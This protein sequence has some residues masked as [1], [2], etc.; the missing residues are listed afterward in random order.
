MGWL[1][2]YCEP[3]IFSA[4]IAPVLDYWLS[5]GRD[6][7][8]EVTGIRPTERQSSLNQYP[9]HKP[10]ARADPAKSFLS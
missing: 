7:F 8:G 6:T 5:A 9:I 10:A 3:L 1:R 4:L 2:Q